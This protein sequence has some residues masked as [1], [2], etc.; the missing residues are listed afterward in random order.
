MSQ[1]SFAYINPEMLKLAREQSG[2]SL[3]EAAGGDISPDKL[4][5][6]ERGE[7]QLTFKQFL[8]IARRYKR[9]PAYFYL[10]EPFKEDIIHDFR[11]LESKNVKFSPLLRDTILIIKEKRELA[12]KYQKYDKEYDYS[13]IKSIHIGLAIDEVANRIMELLDLHLIKRKKWKTEYDA[14]NAWKG[15][16]ENIGILVFQISKISI[17]EMRGFSISE[18][19]YPT[20]VLNRKDSPLGRIF[21]LIHEVCHLMLKQGGICRA[22]EK[23]EKGSKIE[24]FCN[25]VAGSVLVPKE[26]LLI[27]VKNHYSNKWEES[28]LK[29]LKK[30]FWASNEVILRRL[31]IF[32]KTNKKIYQQKRNEWKKISGTRGEGGYERVYERVLRTHSQNYVKIVLNAMQENYITFHDTSFYLSMSL[33]H[34]DNLRENLKNP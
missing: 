2:F 18:I 12:V 33:K 22:D 19:P 5:K 8:K 32:N 13:Y 6:A 1:T 34:L 28:E 3:R 23:D 26:D 24:Y 4:E 11:T 17:N 25:A 20:I 15:A 30:I 27:H 9:P 21:T 29:K 16:V 31:L 10:K 14:Y 7:T